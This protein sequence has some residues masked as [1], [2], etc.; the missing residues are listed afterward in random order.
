MAAPANGNARHATGVA[1]EDTGQ[2]GPESGNVVT[3]VAE[4]AMKN[5][6]VATEPASDSWKLKKRDEPFELSSKPM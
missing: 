1:I 6:G 4:A 3:F 2:A 5:A